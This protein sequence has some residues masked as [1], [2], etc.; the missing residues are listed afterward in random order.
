MNKPPPRTEA[1]LIELCEEPRALGL[2]EEN[3]LASARCGARR[4]GFQ[5]RC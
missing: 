3:D 2:V 5:Q 1:E 4:A